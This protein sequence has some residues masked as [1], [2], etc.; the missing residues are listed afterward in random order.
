M[1]I[2]VFI[3]K[4][5]TANKKQQDF[6]DAVLDRLNLVDISPRIMNEN[7]WSH[8]QP[9]KAIKKIINDCSGI[10]II[11]FNRTEFASGMEHKG[12]NSILLKDIKL[13]T[14]WNHIEAAIAYSYNMPLLVIAEEGLKKEGLIEDGYD[15]RVF[16]TDMT[17]NEIKSNKFE[18]FLKSWKSSV[19]EFNKNKVDII[20][21][22]V[23]PAN[24]SI[25]KLFGLLTTP[26][27]WKLIG[28]IFLILG[29]LTTVSYKLGEKKIFTTIKKNS[30]PNK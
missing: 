1:S 20:N 4:G 14:T 9:L 3:S 7:E 30:S 12:K 21:D 16:W 19:V 26:Q 22:N 24:I 29:V 25:S 2:K 8:E 6:V 5:S 13:P 10:V 15:W 17:M 11:A 23:N 18:G 28:S 27:I